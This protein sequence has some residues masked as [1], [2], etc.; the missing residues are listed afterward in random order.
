MPPRKKLEP[1][2]GTTP[3]M[4]D[5]LPAE[6]GIL[7]K[8]VGDPILQTIHTGGSGSGISYYKRWLGCSLKAWFQEQPNLPPEESDNLD[9]GTITHSFLK[10]YHA[11]E[12]G[13]E[14]LGRVQFQQANGS[15]YEFKPDVRLEAERLFRAYRANFKP[16]EFGKVVMVERQFP[17]MDMTAGWAIAKAVGVDPFTFQLDLGVKISEADCVRLRTTRQLDLPGPGFYIVDHKTEGR[18]DAFIVDKWMNELQFIAYPLGLHAALPSLD[19]KGTI[20][21]II[22]KTK[23]VDFQLLF[24]PYPSE[25]KIRILHNQLALAVHNM[26]EH[27]KQAN[28]SRCLDY[29]KVCHFLESGLCKQH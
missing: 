3:P 5:L 21:N 10:M 1:L 19:I 15:L 28:V 22:Y 12:L 2:F 20:V 27:T 6:A 4:L 23:V 25:I 26:V 11:R 18:H 29:Y 13:I 16:T 24:V 7:A 9:I 8:P 14:E 17:G